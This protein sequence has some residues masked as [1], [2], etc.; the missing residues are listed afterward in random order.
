MGGCAMNFR[1]LVRTLFWE[2][3]GLMAIVRICVQQVCGISLPVDANFR[4]VC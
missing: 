4:S 2:W 3:G 1:R